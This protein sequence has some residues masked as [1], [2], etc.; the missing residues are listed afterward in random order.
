MGKRR[1]TAD[2]EKKI[3]QG[4][5]QG[6]EEDYEPYY[7]VQDIP[8]KGRVMRKNGIRANRLHTTLSDKESI[9]SMIFELS[10]KVI[11]DP[12]EQFALPLNETLVIAE[13]LGIKHPIHPTTKK[14]EPL[15]PDFYFQIKGTEHL[16][17]DVIREFKMKD[18]L[19]NKR[20]L[21]KFEIER[22]W[23][24]RNGYDWGIITEEEL[25]PIICKN[26]NII[27]DYY[28]INRVGLP[29]WS[30]E[31]T[32]QLVA[33][34]IKRAVD[35]TESMRDICNTLD[36]DAELEPYTC[37]NLF[38]HLV[39]QNIIKIDLREPIDVSKVIRVILNKDKYEREYL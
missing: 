36:Q 8:S 22:V 4:R 14:Y 13:E 26:I 11:G 21:E 23:C 10:D 38:K 18:D 17:I 19:V 5:C 31:Q 39:A 34:F 32:K 15:V 27:Y 35:A 7:T 30:E 24:E 33:E 12:L 2:Y 28:F 16:P 29:E 6:R 3:E 1:S 20:V 9:C 37:L 25:N